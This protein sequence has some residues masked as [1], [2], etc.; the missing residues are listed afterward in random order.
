[1]KTIKQKKKEFKDFIKSLE[2]QGLELMD[3]GHECVYD[4]SRTLKEKK[5][6]GNEMLLVGICPKYFCGIVVERFNELSK[7]FRD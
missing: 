4:L 2:K 6:T 3:N 1:M 7:Q 5:P